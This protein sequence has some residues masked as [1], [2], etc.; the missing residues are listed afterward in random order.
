MKRGCRDASEAVNDE[1]TKTL[2]DERDRKRRDVLQRKRG[3]SCKEPNG[4]VFLDREAP[5]ITTVTAVF[6]LSFDTWFA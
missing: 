2:R 5:S 1:K 3:T 6:S 4:N